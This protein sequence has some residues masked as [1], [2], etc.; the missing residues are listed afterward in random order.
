MKGEY[1]GIRGKKREDIARKREIER[2]I[3]L[4]QNQLQTL[5]KPLLEAPELQTDVSPRKLKEQKQYFVEALE[6]AIE[7]PKDQEFVT[8]KVPG[9]G[10]YRF[11]NVEESLEE[12]LKRVKKDWPVKQ[13]NAKP[14]EHEYT[15][16]IRGEPFV[17][18]EV[19]AEEKEV[20]PLASRT[21]SKKP[22]QTTPPETRPRQPTIGKEQAVARSKILQLFRKAFKDPIRLGKF[23]QKAAGIHKLWPKVTRLLKDNDVETAAHEIGHNL[24]TTLYGGDAKNP[25]EQAHNINS[26]LRPYLNELKPLAHYEP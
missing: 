2:E 1:E 22:T 15:S 23:K 7:N 3:A 11:P 18:E 16:K 25:G 19:E 24:H 8:V 12:A 6:D 13:V 26:A 17:A 9:D 4:R 21:T 10:V 14:P 20:K 5:E